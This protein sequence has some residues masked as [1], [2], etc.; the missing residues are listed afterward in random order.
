L[1]FPSLPPSL[2]P[3]PGTI[4]HPFLA[5]LHQDLGD[6]SC[7][8]PCAAEVAAVFHLSL[9][10]L[11]DPTLAGREDLKDTKEGGKAREGGRRRLNMPYF[12][13]GP[14]KVWGLTAFITEGVL[15]RVL[16]PCLEGG[17]EGERAEGCK[18]GG[19]GRS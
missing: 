14:A 15:A 5:F 2:P 12:E 4:V 13:G 7:F 3:S 18:G 19:V 16:R 10:Q 11:L 9:P 8:S 17:G 6:L 1:F